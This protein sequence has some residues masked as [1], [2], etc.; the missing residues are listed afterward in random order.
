[1]VDN[2]GSYDS[3][4]PGWKQGVWLCK[5]GNWYINLEMTFPG[6]GTE[7][8]CLYGRD[9][10]DKTHRMSDLFEYEIGRYEERKR[11]QREEKEAERIRKEQEAWEAEQERIRKKQEAEQE[12]IRKEQEAWEAEQERIRKKQEAEQERIRKEQ[13]AWEAEQEWIRKI[14][15]AEQ[16]RIRKKQEAWEA[17]QERI[18]KEREA[19]QERIRKVQEAEEE[20]LRKEQKRYTNIATAAAAICQDGGVNR[21]Q[22]LANLEAR[23]LETPN[24]SLADQAAKK[25]KA[26]SEKRLQALANL[27]ARKVETPNQALED[28]AAKKWNAGSEKRL[29]ALANLEARKLETPNQSLADQ[30]AKKWKAG[31]EKR[32][33]ALANLE[34][35]K[36]ETPNQALE[37]QA[38]KKWNAGSEKRLQALANLETRKVET[39]N[40]TLED[41]A[42]KKWNAG[43]EKRLQAL[44][45]LEARKV[46]TP[47]QTLED[48]AA[49]KWKAGSE[50]RLQALANLEA[51]KAEIP[52]QCLEDQAAKKW[53]AGSEKR[54]QA[55]ANLE[56]RKLE[57]PSQ[58][59]AI[60]VER[61]WESDSERRLQLL[62]NLEAKMLRT[63]H[64]TS[65]DKAINEWE[66][67]AVL[68][69]QK[70]S[71]L[72]SRKDKALH[73]EVQEKK[74]HKEETEL[75]SVHR[76]LANAGERRRKEEA[77]KE[78][79]HQRLVEQKE[80][81][82]KIFHQELLEAR[83]R[84]RRQE[85][86]WEKVL[87]EEE[88]RAEVDRKTERQQI[89]AEE[90]NQERKCREEEKELDEYKS[91]SIGKLNC[92][93]HE[94]AEGISRN[95]EI[96]YQSK[97]SYQ[98]VPLKVDQTIL[99]P[100]SSKSFREDCQFSCLRNEVVRAEHPTYLAS[101]LETDI[102]AMA[103]DT[104]S[105][106][107][108][109]KMEVSKLLRAMKTSESTIANRE[110][111]MKAQ[112]LC[113]YYFS[114]E[115]GL[116]EMQLEMLLY[117]LSLTASASS[118]HE[119]FEVTKGL[120]SLSLISGGTQVESIVST[121]LQAPFLKWLL[122]S[123]GIT[124]GSIQGTAVR[125]IELSDKDLLR[126]VPTFT[127]D[128]LQCLISLISPS[129]SRLVDH[130]QLRQL[131]HIIHT[132]RL[133][134]C[135]MR[136]AIANDPHYPHPYLLINS[137]KL[138]V[139]RRS[140]K[141]LDQ[142]IEELSH[143]PELCSGAVLRLTLECLSSRSL[144]YV[145]KPTSA[146]QRAEAVRE[147]K[148]ALI[149][150]NEGKST[151]DDLVLAVRFL[152]YALEECKKYKPRL[153][154]LVCLCI[155]I[156]SHQQ[157]VNRLLEVLTG[158]G[159]SCIIAMFAAALAMQG[160]KVDIVTSSPVLAKRD[161]QS[162]AK[163]FRMC[164]L[165]SDHN[166]ETK[167][168]LN[169]PQL[170]A[171]MKRC[172]IYHCDIVYGTVSS[173]SADILREEFEMRVVR[174]N[175]GFQA[176]II[177]EMDMLMMD[178]GVQFTYLSHRLALLRH[179][180]PVIALTWS[181]VQH[182]S[183]LVTED[184]TI[185]FAEAAKYFHIILD[186]IDMNEHPELQEVVHQM[187][188][189]HKKEEI[190]PL[191]K[192]INTSKAGCVKAYILNEEGRLSLAS[193][194]V[195]EDEHTSFLLSENG[196]VHRL[197][198]QEKVTEGVK[199][200]VLSHCNIS[201][202]DVLHTSGGVAYVPGY[203]G[204]FDK[205][206]SDLDSLCQRAL[207]TLLRRGT[208]HNTIEGVL[209]S[210]EEKRRM[211]A[212]EEV[213]TQDMLSFIKELNE[214]QV[215]FH[216][217]AYTFEEMY[218]K[219][220]PVAGCSEDSQDSRKKIS[221][222]VKDK[223]VLHPLYTLN[224][225]N[226]NQEEV[227]HTPEG[228]IFNRGAPDFLDKVIYPLQLLHLCHEHGIAHDKVEKVLKAEDEKVKK[229]A[230]GNFSTHDVLEILEFLEKKLPCSV[231]VYGD[232][233]SLRV[234][235]K[236]TTKCDDSFS[237]LIKDKGE[238]CLLHEEQDPNF[239]PERA[240]ETSGGGK[241]SSGLLDSF[242][243][244]ICAAVDSSKLLH[245]LMKHDP[246]DN[247]EQ[248]VENE[249]V[250]KALTYWKK[251]LPLLDKL[252][253]YT[254]DGETQKPFTR[255]ATSLNVLLENG[256]LCRLQ[257]K[258]KIN[259]TLPSSLKGFVESQLPTYIESAFTAHLMTEN[260]EYLVSKD[261]K[262]LPID[263]ENSGIIE[264]NK[265][266]G[267]G[268]QQMLEMKHQ[269]QLSPM[270]VVTNF[271][272]HIGFFRRYKD[273]G[274]LFGLTGTIGADSDCEVPKRLYNFHPCRIPTFRQRLL[275]ERDPILV[276][277]DRIH[278]LNK[279]QCVLKSVT[280]PQP[281]KTPGRAAL[282]L[283]ED[284]RT[285]KEI[286]D[287]LSTCGQR[288]VLYTRNDV[289]GCDSFEDE[290]RDSG[291]IIVATNLAG[292]GTDIRLTKRVNDSGGLFCLLTFLPRNRR[293]E[294][295]AF[296]RTARKGNPGSVQLIL[297]ASTS[298]AENLEVTDMR[299]ARAKA[300]AARLNKMVETDVEEVLLREEL[301]HKHCEFLESVYRVFN[302][303]K[304]K[305]M[306]IDTVNENWGQW[307]QTK[308]LAIALQRRT[309]LLNELDAA[310][311]RWR[312]CDPSSNRDF[313]PHIPESN[314]CH[315]VK[316][317]NDC[318]F[319][320]D[321]SVKKKG[322]TEA[323]RYYTE[324]IRM[325]P[326]FTMVA[327]Y[328]RACCTL[329]AA[330]K[331]Y[332]DKS[333]EDLR[334][335][336]ELLQIHKNEV[337]IV[338]QCTAVSTRNPAQDH[339]HFIRQMETRMQILQYFERQIHNTLEQ[340]QE[341]QK[342]KAG[343]KV[344]PTSILE[345]IPVSDLVTNEELYGLKLLGL[346]VAF[347]V[348]KKPRFSWE[349]LGVFILGCA[350]IVAGVCLA[351]FTVG[352]MS[353][354]GM[355]LISEG[356][357]DCIDGVVGMVTGEFDLK[358]WGI[359]KA[360]SIAL[361]VACGGAS[362]FIVKGAKAAIKGVKAGK[363]LKT[364]AKGIKTVKGGVRTVAKD[365]KM[366]GTVAK[367]SWGTSLKSGM[368][369]A[370][371]IVGKE[372]ISQ[373]VMYGLNKLENLAIERIFID[374]GKK[375]AQDV[376][377]SLQR[378][379]DSSSKD[380]LG[381]F[382]DR[383]YTSQYPSS[384]VEVEIQQF[385]ESIAGEAV[386]EIV[387]SNS[388]QCEQIVRDQILP[389]L[390]D[391]S[392]GRT[393][394]LSK[395]VECGFALNSLIETTKQLKCVI[396]QF[397]PKMVK[398]GKA[399]LE[400][401]K[402]NQ[403]SDEP[404]QVKSSQ[405]TDV[406]QATGELENVRKLKEHIAERTADQFGE[407]V[408][409]VLQQNLTWIL[410]RGLSKTVNRVAQGHLNKR[411]GT[412]RTVREMEALQTANYLSYMTPHISRSKHVDVQHMKSHA[413]TIR[414]PQ[415][416]G[417][418]AELKVAVEKLNCK[419]IVE[420]KDGKRIRSLESD[421]RGEERPKI[422]LVHTPCDEHHPNGHYDIKI[423][424]KIIEV[425][426]TGNN[427]M[428]EAL[429]KGLSEEGHAGHSAQS[430]RHIVSDEI[431][432]NPGMWHDHFQRKE[433]LQNFRN[434]NLHLL[435]GGAG[436][437][438][439]EPTDNALS[440]KR[441]ADGGGVGPA[442]RKP[443]NKP[444]TKPKPLNMEAIADPGPAE[445]KAPNK[446]PT[447]H[448][449]AEKKATADPGPVQRKAPNKPPTK[450][451]PAKKKA[452]ADPSPAVRKTQNKPPTKPKSA[453]EEAIADP[454]PVERKAPN[455]PPTKPKPAK[456]EAIADP[457][458]AERK[459]SNKPPTKPKPAK[460]EAIADPGP[461]ERKAPNK[462]PTKPKPAREE[463]I[464][465]P[466]PA[467]RKAPNK[468]PTKPKPA[469]EEAIADPGPAER[470]APNK[471][472]TKPKPAKNKETAVAEQQYSRVMLDDNVDY[473]TYR[474]ENGL[475]VQSYTK[476]DGVPV[477][478]EK[479]QRRKFVP[480]DLMFTRV[481]K[482]INLVE[483]EVVAEKCNFDKNKGLR[484]Q[485]TLPSFKQLTFETGHRTKDGSAPVSFHY[486]ASV[487][488]ANAGTIYGNSGTASEHYNKQE[489]KVCEEIRKFVNEYYSDLERNGKERNFT[490]TAKVEYENLIPPGGIDVAVEQRNTQIKE[491]DAHLPVDQRRQPVIS[492][493]SIAKLD[494]RFKTVGK[495][496]TEGL[497]IKEG[498]DPQVQRIKGLEYKVT[499]PGGTERTF[500]LGRDTE[501]Y[502]HSE[503]TGN[504]KGFDN[505]DL[506]HA[507][508]AR[509]QIFTGGFI[510]DT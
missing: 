81:E 42:A 388:S 67:K 46:E 123:C 503:L 335:A 230:L 208:A 19:E 483:M 295:Q 402:S 358:E 270:S 418:L 334:K 37:D 279:I 282:V 283:C 382:I 426:S 361:S 155:L 111:L 245:L 477:G 468:P 134:V 4:D 36:V 264:A 471:P 228:A 236:P 481:E 173:F 12:R 423:G 189:P 175:R 204:V 263:Y 47:N 162:W 147:A 226:T 54:L 244:V 319:K 467:E 218:G 89:A 197:F 27:E 84:R 10:K 434:G 222:L 262:I 63:P 405:N 368:K 305:R 412:E 445:C 182:H 195:S 168:L 95:K 211:V 246:P 446:P 396:Q 179:I 312:P 432:K 311:D 250:L 152:S 68:R 143:Q 347:S 154:Q 136:D 400:K 437:L 113:L 29:Q 462:P 241:L 17:E 301:F 9:Y 238:L 390:S 206:L 336:K 428:Y 377:E 410:N 138:S 285:A 217:A 315:Q 507:T 359:S 213:T 71:E 72:E 51:R 494:E 375:V 383:L 14:Q 294:L 385:F 314:Y 430:V 438:R 473:I 443:P 323:Y 328:N 360:C 326:K 498:V 141:F 505:E 329:T 223:G 239:D 118:D 325:E 132:Y 447:K 480:K 316:F 278:W 1:M 427:C 327:Y 38:A 308:Q 366:M 261:G 508:A 164:D 74:K 100:G 160:K 8:V 93:A 187:T 215:A 398:L 339:S 258:E 172:A 61:E 114:Q 333:M 475:V 406:N 370:G 442:E 247:A 235:K 97:F 378:S 231:T 280:G 209:K 461:A 60:K 142:L 139:S 369:T 454:G 96:S 69:R 290:E 441:V 151:V 216:I 174:G 44:A 177:D 348:E 133:P 331:G 248:T 59:S 474:Q 129:T 343:A 115:I 351:V 125:T 202:E 140:D 458:P 234:L 192:Q 7:T 415:T 341:F 82:L 500:Q 365:V 33:Q 386:S 153:T 57:A 90:K 287:H 404:E 18:R 439:R 313:V 409:T 119:F 337:T 43:S 495:I 324:A 374:I 240:K 135:S 220:R 460:E 259:I 85:A 463:A 275:Y 420:D 459:A 205:V 237:V 79:E 413:E 501:L 55:L 354:V 416:A 486:I 401:A 276:Q 26:G 300:E 371:K 482:D 465:D 509:K 20:R 309:H 165:T 109:S 257:P 104:L 355:G 229:E 510:S 127:E 321:G 488:G 448:N 94:Y 198:T 493:E 449:P 392:K 345:F 403:A 199:R 350:Q 399:N 184:G 148:N 417:T 389:T 424:G 307:L 453:K 56:A 288:A 233:T 191:I 367:G 105:D 23:K 306:V 188:D 464:A 190:L 444:P 166:T 344:I 83:K 292:R 273:E 210:T 227:L 50:K 349:A 150:I 431:S 457:G 284:I 496:A 302:T 149:R 394:A 64:Q 120:A 183:P 381:Q 303:M 11:R 225:A 185:L 156:L 479:T 293:V 352:T 291:D 470:K 411:L 40:Q 297:Q 476:Y 16:E 380:E 421:S 112:N 180:E 196:R 170:E 504:N 161:K 144:E 435:E 407:A 379:L 62:G 58:A 186:G 387:R 103:D 53:K 497:A 271:I 422:T 31:S 485:D 35:R 251:H 181:A 126:M 131:I 163:F 281:D 469:K 25:W 207:Y 322:S 484:C 98:A 256:M 146:E 86:R 408:S 242:P 21:L 356:V 167:E 15:E 254:I 92:S 492:K 272:S 52:N 169:T 66:G 6:Y 2:Y 286:S 372:L 193:V 433:L 219:L 466:G 304:D 296:G 124:Y 121:I 107:D 70:I 489:R 346:E 106:D 252:V 91:N 260:R 249:D 353:S 224:E 267:G 122:Y 317:G 88:I 200:M 78:A 419:V 499:L 277:G 221:V 414:N 28:Q 332:L 299:K 76:T 77:E 130:D 22:A 49:K 87:D 425:H 75:E 429:A 45:N 101:E 393:A 159:K 455:K 255:K 384:V 110:E 48:Q 194:S 108:M 268:L 212:L 128:S 362:K 395:L 102:L 436:K 145:Q 32:L 171:D 39:P 30:A 269:L 203:P 178:E 243:N 491:E 265:R 342:K 451:N 3:L 391:Q 289:E 487:L 298:Q 440:A 452:T 502:V 340:L 137:L 232:L 450:L 201:K 456:E 338:S 158:E 472:P 253:M 80:A 330:E 34:A 357:S 65:A 99:P 363:G 176:A 310:H 157:K 364:V 41:Q 274:M 73:Q 490:C 376:Q 506:K 24:Q 214:T 117:S 397:Q 373:G 116:D 478:S 5:G 266:W 318:L 320:L 13:E